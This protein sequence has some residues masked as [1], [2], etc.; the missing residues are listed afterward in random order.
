MA[1]VVTTNA[2]LRDRNNLQM[3]DVLI[4]LYPLYLLMHFT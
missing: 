4:R 2:K 1:R 3:M